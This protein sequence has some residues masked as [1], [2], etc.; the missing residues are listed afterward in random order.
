MVKN[1][2]FFFLQCSKNLCFIIYDFT[3]AKKENEDNKIKNIH[4]KRFHYFK[5][6]LTLIIIYIL[7]YDYVYI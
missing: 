7:N 3:T 6:V 5:G 1:S 2:I 4:K